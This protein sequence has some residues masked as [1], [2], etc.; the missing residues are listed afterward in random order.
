VN[1]SVATL[2]L[3]WLRARLRSTVF[4]TVGVAAIVVVTAAFYPS[5][6]TFFADFHSQGSAGVNSLL[7]FTAGIDPSAPLGYLWS[8]LYS[9]IVPWM[10][11]AL[12]IALG[13]AGIA[14][15][16][17]AGTLEYT[18]STTAT[19]RQILITRFAGPRSD[20]ASRWV[21]ADAYAWLQG[22]RDVNRERG[23]STV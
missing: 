13:A 2:Y 4:W 11:M 10:L 9:N 18:L 16:E 6:K 19:R 12:G 17:E 3:G 1:G 7:G 23:A 15:D 20:P 5:L 22:A 14:A 8:N 21:N